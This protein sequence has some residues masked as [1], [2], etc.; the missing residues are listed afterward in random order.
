MW[1]IT[2]PRRFAKID[3]LDVYQV[4]EYYRRSYIKNTLG[5]MVKQRLLDCETMEFI[6][7]LPYHHQIKYTTQLLRPRILGR[8]FLTDAE[9][10]D[11]PHNFEWT[12]QHVPSRP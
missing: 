3:A 2:T 11:D 9:D 8:L 10:E 7:A 5:Q 1:K 4:L 12:E 6:L